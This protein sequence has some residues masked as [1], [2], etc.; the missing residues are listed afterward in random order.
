MSLLLFGG[1]CIPAVALAPPGAVLVWAAV[2]LAAAVRCQCL[3][4]GRGCA[5]VHGAPRLLCLHTRRSACLS[6]LGVPAER[7]NLTAHC[8]V[9]G[10]GA[11]VRTSH[12]YFLCLAADPVLAGGGGQGGRPPH[13][14]SC[15]CARTRTR[16]RLHSPPLPFPSPGVV[17][18]LTLHTGATAIDT[19]H[20]RALSTLSIMDDGSANTAGALGWG[21]L[22]AWMDEVAINNN[23]NNHATTDGGSRTA[24]W[25]GA[26][27]RGQSRW[28][29]W[30]GWHSVLLV[31][32]RHVVLA[33]LPLQHTT[34]HGARQ[35]P[36]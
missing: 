13:P 6:H 30:H 31:P 18:L 17:A 2:R 7:P 14:A 33:R 21:S 19:A 9:C 1:L 15:C 26:R 8:G 36:C 5:L 4:F 16:T 25:V 12:Q 10:T 35:A 3:C 34:C 29:G 22:G 28:W 20:W 27:G 32:R 11:H 23:I 24:S